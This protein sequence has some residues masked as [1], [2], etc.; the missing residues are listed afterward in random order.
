[1]IGG[2]T[3]MGEKNGVCME[4]QARSGEIYGT[5]A[6]AADEIAETGRVK[7]W[8]VLEPYGPGKST[9]YRPP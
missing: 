1:M 2:C 9:P 6:A 8:Y 5:F 4:R 7:N 3:Y